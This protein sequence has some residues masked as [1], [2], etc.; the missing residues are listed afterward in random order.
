MKLSQLIGYNTRKSFFEKSYTK[1]GK[2][3]FF[4]KVKIEY[5][6]GSVGYILIKF[7]LTIFQVKGY[8]NILKLSYRPLVFT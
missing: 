1:C 6:S 2:E 4:Q 5:I 7:V 8:R 3:N